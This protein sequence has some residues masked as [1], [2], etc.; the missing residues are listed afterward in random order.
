[1]W[2]FQV[3]LALAPPRIVCWSAFCCSVFWEEFRPIAASLAARAAAATHTAHILSVSW[4]RQQD[5]GQDFYEDSHFSVPSA[6]FGASLKAGLRRIAKVLAQTLRTDGWS[7]K[8]NVIAQALRTAASAG[9][10]N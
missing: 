7:I 3:A 1:M 10:A 4:A 5:E 2:I 9:V 8:K 6:P